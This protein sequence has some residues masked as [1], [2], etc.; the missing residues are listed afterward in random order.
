M[1]TY[2]EWIECVSED[3]QFRVFLRFDLAARFKWAEAIDTA[4]L[5]LIDEDR[6]QKYLDD[7]WRKHAPAARRTKKS[8]VLP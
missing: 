8:E 2:G 5:A 1:K 7:V 6:L 4:Y 3:P